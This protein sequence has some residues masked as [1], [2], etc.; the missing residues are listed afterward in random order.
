METIEDIR[1]KKPGIPATLKNSVLINEDT[2]N[3]KHPDGAPNNRVDI[4]TGTSDKSNLNPKTF[5]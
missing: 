3:I 1:K 5:K 2:N 4:K